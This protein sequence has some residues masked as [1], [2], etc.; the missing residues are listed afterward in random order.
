M[1]PYTETI[2]GFDAT[3]EMV[4]IPGGTFLMGSPD[5]EAGR[6]ADESPLHEVTVKPFWMGKFEVTWDTFEIYA[7]SR[8]LRKKKTDNVD[9]ATQPEHE[10]LADAVTRPTAPYVDMTFGMGRERQ[11]ALCHTHHAAMEYCRWLAAKMNK[12]YRLPTEAEWEWAARAGT[13]TA[14]FFGDD[15]AQLSEYAW[16][17]DNAAKKTHAVGEKKPNPWGLHDIYGNV[18]EWCMDHYQKSMYAKLKEKGVAVQPVIIPTEEEYPY[19]ARGGAYDDKPPRLRS[20]ARRSS[21]EDWSMQDPQ[22]PKSI[23]W[24]TDAKF[25][26]F[27]VV[28]PYQEQDNLKG[29]K[30]PIKR[31]VER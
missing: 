10:K 12:P 18:A 23:W 25:V 7:F 17:V 30:S 8:D 29:V 19:V 2:P 1:K 13:K 14:Y 16:F 26:G 3:I 21:D 28:R 11:P 27:R 5:G 15:P 20:A 4:P 9:L 31:Q 22:F 24:H 6:G